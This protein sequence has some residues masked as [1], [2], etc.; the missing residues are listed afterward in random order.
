MATKKSPALGEYSSF[1]ATAFGAEGVKKAGRR[2]ARSSRYR[3]DVQPPAVATYRRATFTNWA[4]RA[5]TR[6][7]LARW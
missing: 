4:E 2:D 6:S 1:F 5:I 7:A 3:R